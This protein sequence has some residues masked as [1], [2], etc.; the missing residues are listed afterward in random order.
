MD[1]SG[2]PNGLTQSEK[3]YVQHK[4]AL[5][6]KI[7][8]DWLIHKSG[9][10]VLTGNSRMP[11]DVLNVLVQIIAVEGSI[12]LEAATRIVSNLKAT[13]HIIQECW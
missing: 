2:G 3:E 1:A 10:L 9:R 13:G 8:Y 4:I 6:K 12:T 7:V 5:H 11:K